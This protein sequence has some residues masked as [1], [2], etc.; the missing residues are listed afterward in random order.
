MHIP[1]GYLS[2][3]TYIPAYAVA[4]PALT[5]GIKKLKEILNEETYPFIATLTALSFLIMMINIPIPGGTSG[6][7]I[8]TAVISILFNPWIAFVSV[9]FVLLIQS[10]IFG[11]GGITAWSINSIGIGFIA[12]FSAYYSYKLLKKLIKI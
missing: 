12:S 11:D 3:Q 9:S 6:H 2:P 8:G 7:A 10:L 5:Y 1:D 4:I